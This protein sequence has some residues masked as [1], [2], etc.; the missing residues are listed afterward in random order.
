MSKVI[1]QCVKEHERLRIKFYS[2]I[3]EDGESYNNAYNQN[4]NCRFPRNIRKEHC[5]YEIPDQDIKLIK[6]DNTTDPSNTKH[7]APFYNI[8][9][10]NIT[11]IESSDEFKLLHTRIFLVNEC[12]ICLN[13]NTNIIYLPCGHKCNCIECY[14]DLKNLNINKCPL[15]RRMITDSIT[16]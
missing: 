11:I 1:L 8:G 16:L 14:S 6:S 12:V 15:C 2:Y 10:K 13:N 4:Y 9:T 3:S 7:V 5:F